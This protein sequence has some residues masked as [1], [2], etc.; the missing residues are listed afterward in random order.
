MTTVTLMIQ[1]YQLIVGS[2]STAAQKSHKIHRISN[3]NAI[4]NLTNSSRVVGLPYDF[5]LLY[6]LFLIDI[7]FDISLL[8]MFL[9]GFSGFSILRL[10]NLQKPT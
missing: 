6:P 1:F 9:Y 5:K 8:L 7:N 3:I 10:G 2:T 4:P